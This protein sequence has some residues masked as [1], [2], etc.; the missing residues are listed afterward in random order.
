MLLPDRRTPMVSVASAAD[1]STGGSP[2]TDAPPGITP[3]ISTPLGPALPAGE[4]G[5]R[6]NQSRI[7][8]AWSHEPNWVSESYG[9]YLSR[10]SFVELPLP[11]PFHANGRMFLLKVTTVC[12]GS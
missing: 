4:P 5:R 11:G 6:L 1:V 2:E 10:G 3:P 12:A 8:C 7:I 9:M